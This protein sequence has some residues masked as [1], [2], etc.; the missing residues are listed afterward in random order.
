MQ[1]WNLETG[2]RSTN[3]L[4]KFLNRVSLKLAHFFA[5]HMKIINPPSTFK[6]V[7]GEIVNLQI[8][9]RKGPLPLEP[10]IAE[11]SVQV[12]NF[13]EGLQARFWDCS[14]D[15][16]IETYGE[17]SAGFRANY[18]T[19]VFFLNVDR[20]EGDDDD[21]IILQD[22]VIWDTVFISSKS[23]YNLHVF[24]TF[25]G[26]CLS[27][28][29]SKKWLDDNILNAG[30]TVK[31]LK[32]R[33]KKTDVFPWVECMDASE[34]KVVQDAFCYSLKKSLGS[35]Y[36]KS[37]VLKI[38]SDF[39]FKIKEI[40]T[41]NLDNDCA[42][43]SISKAEEHLESNLNGQLPNLKELANQFSISESTLKRHFKKKHGVNMSSYFRRK[44]LEYAEHLIRVKRIPV[45]ETASLLGYPN[46]NHLV[47]L[48]NKH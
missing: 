4:L 10:C 2:R 18:F 20:C 25:K 14:F 36:V 13:V 27:I 7:F 9:K 23:N 21:A 15:D 12:F 30:E 37:A 48:L 35:F 26:Q 44:K 45:S 19:L 22:N 41:K 40:P 8:K 6:V 5:A 42:V 3:I 34:R 47:S 28:S 39:F 32:E 31:N 46:I 11:G 24:P 43:T 16:E 17:L 33:I 29:F 1:P 38:L